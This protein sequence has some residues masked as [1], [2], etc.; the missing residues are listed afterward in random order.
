MQKAS[1]MKVEN[2]D[3][4]GLI[5]GLIDEIGIVQKIN[6]LIGEQPG[7]I[8]SPGLVVKAMI[9][10]GLGMV[11][12]P[13]YLFSKFFEGKAIEH[14]LGSVIQASH[15]ND[16]RLGRVLDKLYLAGI[17]SIFTTIALSAAQKFE[18]NTDT[19]HL[20]SSSFHLHGKYEQELP[21]VAFSTREMDSNQLDNLSIN[22]QTSQIPIQI[23]Y[24]YSRDHRPD[25]KQ[26]ILDLI[27]SGDGDVPLFLR[28][29]S[30]N[31]SDNSV[32]ASICQEFKQQLN[33]DSLMVADSALY[34]APNLEM[35]TNLKWLTRVPGSLKQAQQLVSQLNES[36]FHESEVTGYRWSEHQSNYGGITQR[37]LVVESSLRRDS[38]Q[39]KL[40]KTLKK[41]EVE[42]QKKLRELSNIEFACAADASAAA[43]RLSTQLKYHNL[44]QI[45]IREATAKPATNLTNSHEKSTSRLIFKVQAQ[46]EIDASV[47]ARIIKA[48]GR[49]ILATNVL[50]AEQL[51]PDEMIVKY[52][53]QQSA[54][55]GFGFLKDPLFFTDSVFLK[56]PERIEAL[57]LIMGLCLLV[58][59][60]G[61]RLLRQNLQL[62]NKTVKNQLGKVT[63]RPTLRWIFQTFQSIH[64]VCI[65]G[66]QQVSNLTSER[67]AILNLFP[68]T[69]RSYYF[70]L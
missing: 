47:V 4:L 45:T 19:S 49:F 50:D 70:L 36:E 42:G 16:D 39:R 8:V 46:L 61:Q 55:R 9:I 17:S 13:L 1:E 56:S 27:C 28:V 35:L 31:E 15:L 59:T 34:S 63:N 37:W 21:S 12:A 44:T 30:G 20:D 41:A 58:Y 64:A 10:N 3:H 7:E 26:F 52:K 62:T 22:H 66:I 40:E 32:F 24:G 53:E 29:A 14:L 48:S 54:E 5:A 60:L 6:E 69:C 65:Q 23:T 11:S 33:L 57:T 51:S 25:L 18:I 38:D 68:V 67:L 2:L 43:S